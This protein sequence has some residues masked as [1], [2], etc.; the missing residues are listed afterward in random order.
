MNANWLASLNCCY[1]KLCRLEFSSMQ[2][3]LDKW[4]LSEGA[5]LSFG[6]VIDQYGED[7]AREAIRDWGRH[8]SSLD[9]FEYRCQELAH[10][11][12]VSRATFLMAEFLNAERKLGPRWEAGF[13][14][15]EMVAKAVE[16]LG[17]YPVAVQYDAGGGIAMRN[18][19]KAKI[20]EVLKNE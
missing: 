9:A 13:N 4:D 7:I 3:L 1:P 10:E 14:G 15:A 19:L 2:K 8:P 6:S 20:I 18:R 17:G 16:A 5:K 12:L 11:H